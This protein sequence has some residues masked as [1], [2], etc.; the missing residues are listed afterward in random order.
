MSAPVRL[1]LVAF[2]FVGLGPGSMALSAHMRSPGVPASDLRST[3]PRDAIVP[4]EIAKADEL[5][6]ANT[7][8]VAGGLRSQ[9]PVR[10]PRIRGCA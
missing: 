8:P 4:R 1:V 7:A 5:Q 10:L 2:A 3:L 6:G 9:A